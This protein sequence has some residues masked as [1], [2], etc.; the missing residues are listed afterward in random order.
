MNDDKPPMLDYATPQ[1][2][3]KSTTGK[4]LARFYGHFAA[5]YGTCWLVVVG[6]AVLFQTH[7]NTGLFGLVGFVVIAVIYA[8]M[9]MA[10]RA[11]GH[12]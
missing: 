2:L 1:L 6:A 5:A 9:R 12:E 7:I 8:A 4:W 11:D 3:K 10:A